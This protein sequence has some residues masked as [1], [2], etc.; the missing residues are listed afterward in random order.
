MT[1]PE[2][3]PL[4]FWKW[5][6]AFAERMACARYLDLYKHDRRC[7]N[8]GTWGALGGFDWAKA[9]EVTLWTQALRCTACGVES[10]WDMQGMV[11]VPVV[12]GMGERNGPGLAGHR[13][14][15]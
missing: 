2:D 15:A 4:R 13:H 10:E 6:H 7:P 12:R 9:R 11:P 8:C 5:L 3:R 14:G 1:E